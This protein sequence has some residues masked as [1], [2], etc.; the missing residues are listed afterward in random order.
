MFIPAQ[1]HNLFIGSKGH[2]IH[3]IMENCGGLHIHFPVEGF[4][5]DTVIIRGPK[6]NVK[7]AKEATAVS[8]RREANQEFQIDIQVKPEYHNFISNGGS[9]I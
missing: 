7:K 1:L 6:S 2:F 3:S 8:G 4:G 5:G 9:K